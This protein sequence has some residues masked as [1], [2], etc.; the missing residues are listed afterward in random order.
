MLHANENNGQFPPDLGSLLKQDLT[1]VVFI[2]PLG[3]QQVPTEKL[4]PEQQAQWVNE[5][6]D[7]IYLGKGKKNILRAD[8]LVAYEKFENG[9]NQGVNML[10]GD[11]H[12]EWV[13][14]D[15]AVKFVE[16]SA[17]KP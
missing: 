6:S 3:S 13:T 16:E 2:S 1:P 17:P 11:G 5:H 8:Q 12:V 9:H 15:Q 10:F 14:M 7:Y 4:T